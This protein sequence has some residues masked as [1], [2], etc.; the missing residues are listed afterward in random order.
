MSEVDEDAI[1]E[2]VYFLQLYSKRG[3][4][5]KTLLANF[6][7]LTTRQQTNFALQ[8]REFRQDHPYPKNSPFIT[9]VDR[10]DEWYAAYTKFIVNWFE[11][12]A[13]P[14]NMQLERGKIES[15]FGGSR[16]SRRSRRLNTRRHH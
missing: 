4:P 15:W 5:D 14:F 8:F 6:D 3:L 2:A 12:T 7:T 13:A 16:R 9:F 1:K 11:R 10:L